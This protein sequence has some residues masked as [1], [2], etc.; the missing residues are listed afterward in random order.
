MSKPEQEFKE[1]IEAFI[2]VCNK[3]NELSFPDQLEVARMI[4][5]IGAKCKVIAK[6][7]GLDII[8][9]DVDDDFTKL[10]IKEWGFNNGKK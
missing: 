10:G 5:D 8:P 4:F 9:M 7:N 6:R 1:C 2:A 3:P